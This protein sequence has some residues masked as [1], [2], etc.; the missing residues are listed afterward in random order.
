MLVGLS[1]LMRGTLER[2]PSH[3]T[4]LEVEVAFVQKYVDLYRV[5]FSDRLD[6]TYD[7]DPAAAALAVPTFIL[8]PLVE[9][10]FRHGIADQA[11]R[12]R[13]EI[14]ARLEGR[15]L[16]LW[17]ADDGAGVAEDFVVRRDAGTGLSN[18]L[19]RVESL[20]GPSANVDLR[21]RDTGGTVAS[22]VLPALDVPAVEQAAS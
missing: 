15:T 9:N 12:C 18:V 17:V 4:A 5:R 3:L 11:R 10:A 16:R 20:C 13:V 8:Q 14:G 6:V 7:I 19:S 21:R 2:N 22:L 1:D